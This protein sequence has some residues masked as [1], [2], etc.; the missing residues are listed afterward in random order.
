MSV[1]KATVRHL[2]A[3]GY[4]V[5]MRAMYSKLST[6]TRNSQYVEVTFENNHQSVSVRMTEDNAARL[7]I[8]LETKVNE[9]QAKEKSSNASTD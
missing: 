9:I 1:R 5:L 2:S 6:V 3:R 7:V 4:L 8:Q